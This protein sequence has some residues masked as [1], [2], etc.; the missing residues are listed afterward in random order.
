MQNLF[1]EEIYTRPDKTIP[2][3]GD[4]FFKTNA[5]IFEVGVAHIKKCIDCDLSD[6]TKVNFINELKLKYGP[7]VIN[8]ARITYDSNKYFLIS[9]KFLLVLGY[10]VNTYSEIS[11]NCFWIIEDIDG[12]NKSDFADFLEL[13]M[14]KFMD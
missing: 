2:E 7:L 10:E 11:T 3:Y 5:G 12:V 8:E 13:D 1:I 14:L 4:A 9:N 6:C